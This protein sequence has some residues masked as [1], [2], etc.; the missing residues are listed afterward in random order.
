MRAVVALLA[1]GLLLTALPPAAEAGPTPLPRQPG[2]L[3]AIQ[4][5][6]EKVLDCVNQSGGHFETIP[7]CLLS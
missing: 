2:G 1:A 6:V 3:G 5:C 7:A 4:A